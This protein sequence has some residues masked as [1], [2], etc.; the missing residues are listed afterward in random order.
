MSPSSVISIRGVKRPNST[1]P[2]SQGSGPFKAAVRA[3]IEVMTKQHA[4]WGQHSRGHTLI[5]IPDT[6]L[7]KDVRKQTMRTYGALLAFHIVVFGGLQSFNF[8]LIVLLVLGEKAFDVSPEDLRSLAPDVHA[9]L[10]PWFLLD[11]ESEIPTDYRHPVAKL[12]LEVLG[13]QVS[14]RLRVLYLYFVFADLYPFQPGVLTSN[15]C[16]GKAKARTVGDHQYLTRLC[17]AYYL[18]GMVKPWE[19]PEVLACREGFLH[20][21]KSETADFGEVCRIHCTLLALSHH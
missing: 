3:A 12:L 11:H 17:L 20:V 9:I 2:V 14:S 13:A 8:F 6:S 18:T 4:Y 1:V 5:L 19:A 21:L 10:E 16:G 7:V 15:P